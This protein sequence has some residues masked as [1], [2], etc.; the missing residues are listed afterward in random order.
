MCDGTGIAKD[1]VGH[2]GVGTAAIL[3]PNNWLLIYATALASTGA[4][5]R[6]RTRPRDGGYV[7]VR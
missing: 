6:A 1:D 7:P 3:G 5:S 4:A 2:G